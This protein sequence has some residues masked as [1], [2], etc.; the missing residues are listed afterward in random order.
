M[1][2]KRTSKTV[3]VNTPAMEMFDRLYPDLFSLF[4]ERAVVAAINDRNLFDKIFFPEYN[5]ND[6]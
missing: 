4:V 2:K 3:T 5:T 6:A 1:A